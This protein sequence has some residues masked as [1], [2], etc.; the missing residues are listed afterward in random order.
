MYNRYHIHKLIFILFLIV[1]T[2]CKSQNFTDNYIYNKD[3]SYNVIGFF[4]HFTEEMDTNHFLMG[5]FILVSY[6]SLFDNANNSYRVNIIRPNNGKLEVYYRDKLLYEFPLKDGIVSGVGYG[7]Y[8]N[9][10]RIALQGNFKNGKL[11]GLLFIFDEE[12]EIFECM[13]YSKGI[14]KK[15]IYYIEATTKKD[16]KIRNSSRK[17]KNPLRNDEKIILY[18]R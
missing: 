13:K 7:Y 4:N 5:Q 10:N 3:T 17:T 9:N 1:G 8:L 18:D 15:S 2:I 14:F 6:D 16:L 11:D 12:G